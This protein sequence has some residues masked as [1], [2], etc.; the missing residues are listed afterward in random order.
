MLAK[1][2]QTSQEKKKKNIASMY[3]YEYTWNVE[4]LHINYSDVNKANHV[5]CY[6]RLSF[7]NWHMGGTDNQ[8]RKGQ[9]SVLQRQL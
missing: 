4:K 5:H 9:N 6:D 7:S 8:N 2:G 3:A 1:P